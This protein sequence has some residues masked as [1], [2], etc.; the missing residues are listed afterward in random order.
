[1][2]VA[3]FRRIAL[4]FEGAEEGSHMGNPDF[5]VGG[6]IFATLASAKQGYGNLEA[7][8]GAA[9]SV[10]RRNAG[11]FCSDSWRVGTDGH[12]A[13]SA[14]EGER[15]CSD[16][17]A[18]CGLEVA[19]G[20]ECKGARGERAG[21]A[22]MGR[23]AFSRQPSGRAGSGL[24]H[25]SVRHAGY[26]RCWLVAPVLRCAQDDSALLVDRA[27]LMDS[28]SDGSVWA[29]LTGWIRSS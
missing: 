12:D 23:S 6:H 29:V 26:R 3:D 22:V 15:G 18:A 10:C 24:L 28:L 14:G 20:E 1:M 2:T 7:H 11:G 13:Y 9:G 21:A 16:W 25:S 8:S 4:S 27:G 5:R 19:D 17:C